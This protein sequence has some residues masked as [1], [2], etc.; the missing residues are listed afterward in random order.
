MKT[1]TPKTR[2]TLEQLSKLRKLADPKV[3]E[4]S[5]VLKKY[6]SNFFLNHKYNPYSL[7][8]FEKVRIL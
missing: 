3:A 5:K 1:D 6:A 4:Y 2:P 8:F 7:F